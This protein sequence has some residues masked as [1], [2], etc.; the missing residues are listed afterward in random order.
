[1]DYDVGAPADLYSAGVLL[2]EVLT[3]RTPFQGATVGAVLF[4]HMTARVPELR[5]LGL[6]VPRAL[7]EIMQ[8]LLRKDPRD[9]YQSAEA[10]LADLNLLADFLDRGV[11]EPVFVIGVR[12]RRR[13]LTE[14]AFVGRDEELTALDAQLEKAR[15]GE[16]GLVFLEAESGGGKSRLLAELAQR[17]AR[18]GAWVLR[19]QGLDQAAKRPFQVLA[20]VAAELVAASQNDPTVGRAV[21]RQLGEH[22]AAAC[23]ALP[24][25]AGALGA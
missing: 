14:P 19:G 4:Q 21:G 6:E 10:V 11:G 9:R 25:L 23:A 13:T 20:G 22:R 1:L 8:R 5:G 7:D 3:G 24:E 17:G 2:F 15:R 16:G 12:D 18:Q